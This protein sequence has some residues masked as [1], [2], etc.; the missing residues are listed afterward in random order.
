M[1]ASHPGRTAHPVF[2]IRRGDRRGSAWHRTSGRTAAPAF[3]GLLRRPKA[4]EPAARKVE[5][6]LEILAAE[7]SYRSHPDRPGGASRGRQV[8]GGDLPPPADDRADRHRDLVIGHY[9][10]DGHHHVTT[11]QTFDGVGDFV[12]PDAGFVD[13]QGLP[14]AHESEDGFEGQGLVG[15]PAVRR[16]TRSVLLRAERIT[17]PGCR[18][19]AADLKNTRK[20]PRPPR[21]RAPSEVWEASA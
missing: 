13:G 1:S 19:D 21:D 15:E 7:N 11:F 20:E 6:E 12:E 9:G 3:A 8:G 18:L 4:L 14:F 17:T 5:E 16:P 10:G 2:G